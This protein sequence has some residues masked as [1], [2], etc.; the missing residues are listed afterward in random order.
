VRRNWK[1]RVIVTQSPPLS[2]VE[3]ATKVLLP[4]LDAIL[5]KWRF[6]RNWSKPGASVSRK[7][8]WEA[9][10]MSKVSRTHS[11]GRAGSEDI[12]IDNIFILQL[13]Y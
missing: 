5:K 9:V 6:G 1:N 11:I 12:P 13:N 8:S 10:L 2:S 7:G 3:S 4:P